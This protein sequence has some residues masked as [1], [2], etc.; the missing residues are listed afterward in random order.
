MNENKEKDKQDKVRLSRLRPCYQQPAPKKNSFLIGFRRFWFSWVEMDLR[1]DIEAVI[2]HF[3]SSIKEEDDIN[4][5]DY[6]QAYDQLR[7]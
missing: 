2:R 3:N 7:R 4:L 1:F 5:H 6:I